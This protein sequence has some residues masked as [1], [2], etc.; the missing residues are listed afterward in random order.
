MQSTFSQRLSF[1]EMPH[2]RRR[3]GPIIGF[4][5]E[6][7]DR[8]V[9]KFFKCCIVQAS[10]VDGVKVA[11]ARRT[12]CAKCSDST[13]LAKRVLICFAKK[14][15]VSELRPSRQQPERSWLYYRGPESRLGTDGAI[16]PDSSL[17]QVDVCF[18]LDRTTVAAAA[19][20]LH[21]SS[22]AARCASP[23]RSAHARYS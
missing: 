6:I 20:G 12:T 3:H 8:C 19:I 5:I 23:L 1:L 9:H 21:L 11:P 4:T 13:V 2:F 7:S 10:Q 22:S 15:I 17:A 14:L 16:T 18:K